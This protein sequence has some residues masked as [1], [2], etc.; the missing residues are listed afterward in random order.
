VRFVNPATDYYI[1]YTTRFVD[2]RAQF[3]DA[4]NLVD[5]AALDPYEFLRDSYLQRRR[6]RVYNG[7]PPPA[8]DYE[9]PDSPPADAPGTAPAP[10][11]ASPI[12]N[13]P[14]R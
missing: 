12:A 7:N 10:A 6:S 8:T 14:V 11:P 3:L 2:R 9:D 5:D 1:V 13:P 4:S